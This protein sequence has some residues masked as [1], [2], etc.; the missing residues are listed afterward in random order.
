MSVFCNTVNNNQNPQLD[1]QYCY[2]CAGLQAGQKPEFLRGTGCD[3]V[4]TPLY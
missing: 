4:F 1:I 3:A 2:T